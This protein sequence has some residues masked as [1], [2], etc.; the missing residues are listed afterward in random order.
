MW[1]FRI[2]SDSALQI[3]EIWCGRGFAGRS[4]GRIN[5][6]RSYNV[7]NAEC[8]EKM[9]P[10]QFHKKY[11]SVF[12]PN[13]SLKHY[14]WKQKCWRDRKKHKWIFYGGPLDFLWEKRKN[15]YAKCRVWKALGLRFQS[16]AFANAI[17]S[18][19]PE[20]QYDGFLGLRFQS[21]ALAP[22]ATGLLRPEIQYDGFS[23]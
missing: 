15:V 5:C 19:R 21:L 22:N 9:V 18:L 1:K 3:G 4:F 8:A 17:G 2:C 12:K 11:L 6:V 23:E 10:K 13:F 14:K 7:C 16:L 20:I